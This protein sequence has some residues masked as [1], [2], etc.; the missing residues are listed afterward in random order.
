MPFRARRCAAP[1]A[2]LLADQLQGP[3]IEGRGIAAR[4]DVPLSLKRRR[5]AELDGWLQ[6][7]DE[8][9]WLDC[10]G[11]I[12]TREKKNPPRSGAGGSADGGKPPEGVDTN[13][14]F[15]AALLG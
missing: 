5:N 12:T 7:V 10:P 14:G 9:K 2:D 6:R 1:S 8:S 13:E 3:A 4:G 11:G 15:L